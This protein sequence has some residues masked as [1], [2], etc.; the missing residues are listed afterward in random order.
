MG[1]NPVKF[2]CVVGEGRSVGIGEEQVEDEGR[3]GGGWW[4]WWCLGR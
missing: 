3:G 4:W 2:G 1:R